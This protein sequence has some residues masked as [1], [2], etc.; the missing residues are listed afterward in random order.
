MARRNKRQEKDVAF[1]RVDRLALL[2]DAAL[3]AG[4]VDRANRYADLAWRVKTTYQL[5]GS[6]I[7]GRRCRSCGAFLAPST[8]RVRLRDGKRVV[9]CLAC[10]AARRR[11]LAARKGR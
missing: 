11:V 7:D 6:A 10:G 2:A 4:R 3:A 5:R 1:E 9:T 8:A